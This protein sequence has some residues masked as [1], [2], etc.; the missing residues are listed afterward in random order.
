[1]KDLSKKGRLEEGFKMRLIF[2]GPPGAGKGTQSDLISKNF[3]IPQIA[4]GDILRQAVKNQTELGVLAKKYMDEGKL[5]PDDLVIN[6]IKGRLVGDDC[7]K[8]FIL[9]GFPRTVAQAE[10][11]TLTLK[12]MGLSLDA[13]VNLSLKDELLIKRLCGRRVCRACGYNYHIYYQPPTNES[14]CDKCGGEVYQRDDD[15]EEVINRRLTV[16]KE[17]TYPLIDYYRQIGLLKDV[18]VNQLLKDDNTDTDVE[19][20]LAKVI[21]VLEGC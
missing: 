6:L 17:Q 2:L 15:K 11:L 3:N 20:V 18:N 4:T 5:V 8:G 9:D 19:V 10:A 12:E 16:Y 14:V 21:D 13:V 7:Q 1:M